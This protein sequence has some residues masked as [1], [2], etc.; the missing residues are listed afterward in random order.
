MKVQ[1]ENGVEK[2]TF[3]KQFTLEIWLNVL[4]SEH[5][6]LRFFM[7][8]FLKKNNNLE[9][10][11]AILEPK[12]VE[13]ETKQKELEL[14]LEEKDKKIEELEDE[15]EMEREVAEK[16]LEVSRLER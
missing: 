12:V 6:L 2:V 9:E 10:K 4:L 7:V 11:N 15:V 14:K 13:L 1:K 8:M 3:G 16:A 5:N